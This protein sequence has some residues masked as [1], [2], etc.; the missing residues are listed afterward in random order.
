[1]YLRTQRLN[2]K[3]LYDFINAREIFKKFI[4][5][6]RDEFECVTSIVKGECLIMNNKRIL[7]SRL[8]FQKVDGVR[9]FYQA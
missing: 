1:M 7:H 9:Q 3:T 2:G 4:E 8:P 5:D 6:K